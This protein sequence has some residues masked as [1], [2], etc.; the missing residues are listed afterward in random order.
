[1]K[2]ETRLIKKDELNRVWYVVDAT[3]LVVGRLASKI[4]MCLMGKNKPDYTPHMD[5]GDFVIVLNADK[6]KFT[7]KKLE[8]KMYYDHSG[9]PG[10]IKERTAKEVLERH[11]E[12]V[13]TR[14]VKG[15]LP[16]NFIAAKMLKR[17]KVYKDGEHQHK[18]QMPK[19]MQN[20]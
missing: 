9:Y 4:A 10:G 5:T 12:E 13:I 20:I 14:A 1:M 19:E 16:K 15:M 18:A 8:D 17:L 3:G 11:P 2:K 6:V 7:G